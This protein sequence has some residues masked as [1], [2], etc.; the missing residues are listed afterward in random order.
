MY[1]FQD[2]YN[3]SKGPPLIA[4]LYWQ[5]GL[6]AN[7]SIIAELQDQSRD[8]NKRPVSNKADPGGQ[9]LKNK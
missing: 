8:K 4:D 2:M 9:N 5:D 7:P 3:V 1:H 6:L